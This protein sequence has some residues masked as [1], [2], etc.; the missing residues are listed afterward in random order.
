MAARIPSRYGVR[1]P[2][3]LKDEMSD[4]SQASKC[5]VGGKF[6][7][8]LQEF[9][10]D[11]SLTTGASPI[12]QTDAPN[13]AFYKNQD[14]LDE[15]IAVSNTTAASKQAD[16]DLLLKE[17]IMTTVPPPAIPVV[18]TRPID[19]TT[20]GSGVVLGPIDVSRTQSL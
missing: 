5:F 19:I 11:Y 15:S 8:S 1:I 2:T 16:D 12:I 10:V 6:C 7:R 18:D 13:T 20:L 17:G 9:L 14:Y 4:T 3:F